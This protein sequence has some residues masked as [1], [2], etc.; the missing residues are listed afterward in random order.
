[1]INLELLGIHDTL[2][3]LEPLL[4]EQ[5]L[6]YSLE[7]LQTEYLDLLMIHNPEHYVDFLDYQKNLGKVAESPSFEDKLLD[8]FLFFENEVVKGTIKSY[9]IS[10]NWLSYPTESQKISFQQWPVIAAK[11]Y[12]K[13]HG[14]KSNKDQQIS[15]FKFVQM[16][17]NLLETYGINN[18]AL[19][20]K[21]NGL[22][23]LVNRPLDAMDHNGQ[24]RLASYQTLPNSKYFEIY[25]NTLQSLEPVGD[26]RN[27]IFL[28][29]LI[30]DMERERNTYESIYHFQQDL[31]SQIIPMLHERL[32]I[33]RD[34]NILVSFQIFLNA[35]E[36][37]VREKSSLITENYIETNPAYKDLYSSRKTPLQKFALKY[38][39]NNKNIDC[40]LNGML[41]EEYV[42]NAIE[43]LREYN[44]D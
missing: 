15:S 30:K 40:V 31:N 20:A 37:K 12:E 28:S 19:W 44:R 42:D 8:L 16:P 35:Y 22:G 38:L 10:C 36:T 1:M 2:Y 14:K 25:E 5:Q 43:I 27:K 9:G 6:A 23:V 18:T 3:S 13:I 24:W 34:P 4:F 41:K 17:G 21:Q 29:T 7:N 11:A 33:L 32:N 26:D 39:I